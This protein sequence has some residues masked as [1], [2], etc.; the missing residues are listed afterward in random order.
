MLTQHPGQLLLG[1]LQGSLQLVQLGPGILESTVTSLFSVS[2]GRLQVGA[3][4]NSRLVTL[5]LKS[6][7]ALLH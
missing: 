5:G 1:L 3:L 2:N 7:S 4:G 6:C